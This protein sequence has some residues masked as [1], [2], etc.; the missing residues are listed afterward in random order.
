MQDKMIY[1]VTGQ[2]IRVRVDLQV[3]EILVGKHTTIDIM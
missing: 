3:L 1:K 2:E